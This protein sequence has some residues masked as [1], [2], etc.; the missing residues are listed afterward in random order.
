[1]I[2]C[3]IIGTTEE[4]DFSVKRLTKKILRKTYKVIS[5]L[6]DDEKKLTRHIVSYIFVDLN[7]IH[8]INREYRHIDHPTDVISFAYGDTD[9]IN[10][11][12]Y[13][14]GDIFICKE[15]VFEQANEYNHTVLRECAFLITHGI[16]HLLGYDHMDKDD[17][18]VMFQLQNQILEALKIVR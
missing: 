18:E 15:K 7:E 13:E 4:F 9:Y 12:P 3:N 1:M 16:L 5:N 17:E 11:L 6:K 8:R 2:K 14:L 10:G